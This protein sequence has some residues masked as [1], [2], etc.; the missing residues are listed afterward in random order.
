MS[1][2][3]YNYLYCRINEAASDIRSRHR[4]SPLHMAFAAQLGAKAYE[5]SSSA[6]YGH[7]DR[8]GADVAEWPEELRV[9][10]FPITKESA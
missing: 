3:S 10:Q 1:G 4:N 8:K 6:P 7:R 5:E 2:G 9:R